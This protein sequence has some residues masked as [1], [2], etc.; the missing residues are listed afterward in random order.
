MFKRIAVIAMLICAFTVKA[1]SQQMVYLWPDS[2]KGQWINIYQMVV[3][4]DQIIAATTDFVFKSSDGGVTWLQSKDGIPNQYCRNITVSQSGRMYLANDMGGI[5][6]SNDDG[7]IWGTLSTPSG[8]FAAYS[9]LATQNNLFVGITGWNAHS[10][11]VVKSA[12]DGQTWQYVGPG[13]PNAYPLKLTLTGRGTILLAEGYSPYS[14]NDSTGG[15][16]LR[17]TDEG[18]TWNW[19]NIGLDVQNVWSLVVD[20]T[21]GKV[22][23]GTRYGDIYSS[24]DDG[25]TWQKMQ[26]P[27]WASQT[28]GVNSLLAYNGKLFAGFSNPVSGTIGLAYTKDGG[29][30]WTDIGDEIAHVPGSMCLSLANLGDTLLIGTADGIWAD[31]KVLTAV[32]ST[33]PT[34]PSGF[35]L[36]HNYPNPFNPTTTIEYR[37][38]NREYTTLSVYNVLGQKVATLV[39]EMQSSGSHT[40]TFD[41]SRL[42]SG[43]YFYRLQ[44]GNDVQ[45]KKMILVK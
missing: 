18:E 2:L 35:S 38:E 16:I 34:V 5:L 3:S 23:A 9:I 1:Q 6:E 43:T 7:S 28:S 39:D 24:T 36:S 32:H 40:V 14:K 10:P 25:Q 8:F 13:N 41:A 19:S 22:Y 15:G 21:S 29:A 20:T 37:I 30:T 45:T 27:A 11:V 33:T 31:T 4:Y 17:S 26:G 42:P 12:N 44:A